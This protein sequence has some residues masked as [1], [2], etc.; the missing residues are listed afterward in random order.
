M[1]RQ[2][3]TKDKAVAEELGWS[4][5]ETEGPSWSLLTIDGLPHGQSGPVPRAPEPIG[6]LGLQSFLFLFLYKKNKKHYIPR[7]N[8]LISKGRRGCLVVLKKES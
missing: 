2:S 8:S 3:S 1:A 5:A 6:A 7:Q 4:L